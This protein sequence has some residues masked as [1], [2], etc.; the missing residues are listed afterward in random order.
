MMVRS[1]HTVRALRRFHA[2]A[3]LLACAATAPAWADAYPT[4][5]VKVISPFAPGGGLDV[6]LRPLLQKMGENL[7][8]SFYIENRSGAN[9]MVGIGYGV[10]APADG[11]TLIG[12]TSG[13][14]TINPNIY[15]KMSYDTARDLVPVVNV[16]SAPF[17]MVI[18]PTLPVNNVREFVALVKKEDGK[19]P[20]GSPGVGGTNHLGAEYFLQLTGTHMVHVPYRGSQPLMTDLVGGQVM[21]AFDSV[22]ATV[23]LVHAGKLKALGIASSRR[24]SI[25]PEIPTLAEA[26]GPS[27]ELNSWYG[28]MAPAGTPQD[29]IDKLNS[30]AVKALQ[31]PKLRAFYAGLGIE[32]IGNTPAQ[33]AQQIRN[34]TEL[35][36]KVAREAH[37]KAE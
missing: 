37:V 25:A 10:H 35:W 21:M 28:L 9:G 26:G 7:G 14:V 29:I 31:D 33:F 1:V 30:E 19:L 13:A 34:D 23:P 36:G 27:F 8:Q 20:Y 12:V 22:M 6:V 15:E 11:Y 4:H 17:V 5:A 24:S 2:F 3:L 16:G 32:V 18:N